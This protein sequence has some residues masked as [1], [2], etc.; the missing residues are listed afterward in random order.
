MVF[1]V[2]V[3]NCYDY[4]FF[5]TTKANWDENKS[6]DEEID[7]GILPDNFEQITEGTFNYC[8][9]EDLAAVKGM[10]MDAFDEYLKKTADERREEGKRKLLELGMEQVSFGED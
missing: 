8:R 9:D 6:Y 3:G 10:S 5:I 1:I 4:L 7:E 2:E